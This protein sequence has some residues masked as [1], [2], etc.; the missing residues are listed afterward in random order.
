VFALTYLPTRDIT[1]YATTRRG[2]RSG[3]WNPSGAVPNRFEPEEATD[4]EIGLKSRL[5]D[6]SLTL[7]IAAYQT[8]YKNIQKTQV[9][10]P[11]VTE[12]RN[13]AA[14]RIRG[15][16]LEMLARPSDNFQVG[17]NYTLTDAEYES[18]LDG[19]PVAADF[20][21][22]PFD[23]SRHI[24]TLNGQWTMPLGSGDEIVLNGDMQFFSRRYFTSNSHLLTVTRDPTLVQPAHALLNGRLAYRIASF[25]AEVALVG[26][27][28]LNQ[29]YFVNGTQLRSA[30]LVFLNPGEPRFLGL[31][32]IKRF[33]GETR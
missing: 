17:A 13:A 29:K 20:A 31:Q 11:G 16:E 15:I 25:D 32:F 3:D 26:R 28:I 24:V 4:Y 23:L 1:L 19:F 12:I 10:G 9:T 8:D 5:I 21:A 18:F 6:R 33:G 14:A 7:N 30:G 27:N 2:F 22:E